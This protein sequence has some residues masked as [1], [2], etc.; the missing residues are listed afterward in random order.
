M[1]SSLTSFLLHTTG[2]FEPVACGLCRALLGPCCGSGSRPQGRVK[3]VWELKCQS[4]SKVSWKRKGGGNSDYTEPADYTE[5]GEELVWRG[6]GEERE[7]ERWAEEKRGG[8]RREEER[9][10]DAGERERREREANG[11]LGKCSHL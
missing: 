10:G 11:E 9:R 6:D 2:M 7:G 4:V 1:G 8:D 5:P 3:T